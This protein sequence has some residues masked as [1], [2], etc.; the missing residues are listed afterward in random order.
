MQ[1]IRKACDRRGVIV[2]SKQSS[3]GTMTD[4]LMKRYENLNVCRL[5]FFGEKY[6][7]AEQLSSVIL[8]RYAD[9]LVTLMQAIPIKVPRAETGLISQLKKVIQ[10]EG[11]AEVNMTTESEPLLAQVIAWEFLILEGNN[12]PQSPEVKKKIA[13]LNTPKQVIP[14]S[15][16]IG[17]PSPESQDSDEEEEN[18]EVTDTID[19]DQEEMHEWKNTTDVKP[20]KPLRTLQPSLSKSQY[21]EEKEKEVKPKQSSNDEGSLGTGEEEEHNWIEFCKTKAQLA[22]DQKR[23]AELDA[24]IAK[25]DAEIAKLENVA[26]DEPVTTPPV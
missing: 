21:R 2:S 23:L 1:I 6:K 24:A 4:L 14:S 8:C 11:T 19:T 12:R 9:Q 20:F 18:D 22:A 17:Q 5:P 16:R 7:M 26:A 3:L 25:R 13:S 10:K 15:L